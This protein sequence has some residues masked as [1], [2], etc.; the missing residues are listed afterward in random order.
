MHG[1]SYASGYVPP[2]GGYGYGGAGVQGQGQGGGGGYG[3]RGGGSDVRLEFSATGLKKKDLIG[4][5]DPMVVVYMEKLDVLGQKKWTEVGRTEKIMNDHSPRWAKR[6]MVSYRFYELQRMRLAVFDVD[7]GGKLSYDDELGLVQTDLGHVMSAG[8]FK[9]SLTKMNYV[10][11][12]PKPV[13]G[14]SSQGELTVRVHN[15]SVEGQSK[16]FMTMTGQGLDRKDGLLGKSDPYYIVNQLMPNNDYSV[17]YKSETLK[18]TLNPTWR[19]AEF[20]LNTQGQPPH[21]IQLRVDCYDWDKYTPH[22]LIG[23][24]NVTL[25]QFSSGITF[26]LINESKQK[27]KGKRYTDSGKMTVSGYRLVHFPQFYSYMQAGLKIHLTVGI[28]F[29]ASNGPPSNPK[30]LHHLGNMQMQ[31]QYV[32]ALSSVGEILNSYT[33]DG[34]IAAFGFGAK[35]P[36]NNV[37]SF[38][39]PLDPIGNQYCYGVQGLLEA[40]RQRVASVEFSGP[41]NFAPLIQ[42]ARDLASREPLSARNLTYHCLMILTDGAITDMTN[43]VDA[44]IECSHAVPMSI[45]IIGVGNADFSKMN[46]LDADDQ[47]LTSDNRRQKAKRDIVQFVPFRKYVND[48]HKDGLSADVLAELPSRIVETMVDAGIMPEHVPVAY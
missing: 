17:V 3:G 46:R 12:V 22:D 7:K 43:T 16:V 34:M 33:R 6:V 21:K 48:P 45:V 26:G 13:Q 19:P 38:N 10:R 39:F 15:A 37:T 8:V 27:R 14:S 28:D 40:Y 25:S 30:S 41:T 42:T 24:A 20:V 36:P 31:N 32:Q 1:Q 47:V 4:K 18:G 29:T 9:A 2:G 11:G 5:S 35:Q 44:I 23:R